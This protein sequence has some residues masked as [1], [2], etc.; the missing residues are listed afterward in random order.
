MYELNDSGVAALPPP[1]CRHLATEGLRALAEIGAQLTVGRMAPRHIIGDSRPVLVI[2]GFCLGD[3]STRELRRYLRARGFHT[4]AWRLGPNR[5]LTDSLLTGARDRLEQVAEAHGQP[6]SLIGW[7]LGGLFARWL[8]H[9]RP[10]LVDHV[11]TLASPFRPEGERT[12]ATFL[13]TH[14][15]DRWGIA[16]DIDDVVAQI[17]R[18][19]PVRSTSIYSLTDG[20]LNWRACQDLESPVRENIAIRGSHCGLTHNT[21]ALAVIA[22]RLTKA[23][24]PDV[25]A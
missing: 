15:A 14:A 2:P 1:P 3:N 9:D 18:P 10:H 16:D 19:L 25:A 17:R 5:G 24:E 21:A 8:A 6:V 23:A 13:F 22:D 20:I 11:V 7:S 4:H 12:R